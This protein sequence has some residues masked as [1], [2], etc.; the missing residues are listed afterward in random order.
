MYRTYEFDIH[1][2]V[3]KG[4]L[5]SFLCSSV[6]VHTHIT[7]HPLSFCCCCVKLNLT[8]LAKSLWKGADRFHSINIHHH[9][10]KKDYL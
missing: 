7:N 9:L 5:E 4:L 3:K 10:S 8:P 6:L 1:R 2:D